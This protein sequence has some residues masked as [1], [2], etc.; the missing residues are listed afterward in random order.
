MGSREDT[1][2]VTV[3]V[4]KGGESRNL[5]VFDTWA[6]GEVDS[7]NSK[8]PRGGMQPEEP[9][10]GR[11]TVGDVTVGRLYDAFMQEQEPWLDAGVGRAEGILTKQP[12][13]DDGNAFGRPR[14]YTGKLITMTPPDHDS[15]SSDPAR[16]ELVFSTRGNIG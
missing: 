2:V 11:K 8:Y 12:L 14:V 6:G 16:L 5:G 7:D 15:T 10:G 1:F 9:L 3:T 4:I 13:D